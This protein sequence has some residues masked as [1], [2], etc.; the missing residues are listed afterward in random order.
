MMYFEL[1]LLRLLV[2]VGAPL[3]LAVLAVGPRRVG[4]WFKRGWGW[5]WEKRLDPGELLTRVVREQ[6]E[7]IA[8]LRK[9]LQQAEATEAEIVRNAKKS[10]ENVAALEK[11]AARLAA[12]H[13]DLGAR[14]A[15][16][17]LNLERLAAD[18]FQ[19]QLSRQRQQIVEARRRL[20]LLE[21]Q[22]RQYEVG[23]SILLSQLADAQTIEQQFDIA[24]KFDPFHAV[25]NWQKA[26][27][28]VQEKA[29]NARAVEQVFND[30][31]EMPLANQPA[32]VDPATL[33]AQLAELK[34]KM[35]EKG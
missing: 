19:E 18:S 14:A 22:L 30:L 33:D 8:A 26:E 3:L 20:Y 11:E 2:W 16:Y 15:L 35:K 17:K 23:R 10:E 6:E 9:A 21:L 32:Q 29:V 4:N 1:L 13:D 31:A 34:R 24:S 25:E 5:L 28:L 27:G 7:R 12:Q